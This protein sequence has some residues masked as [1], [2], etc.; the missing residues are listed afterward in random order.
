[1]AVI[2]EMIIMKMRRFVLCEIH[3]DGGR[4]HAIIQGILPVTPIVRG[5]AAQVA[6]D[7]LEK[8]NLPPSWSASSRAGV[9]SC[10]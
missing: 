8:A 1:M 2:F 3:I 9:R 6:D 4:N 10:R 7:T 5:T